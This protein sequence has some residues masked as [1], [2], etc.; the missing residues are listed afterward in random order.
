[1]N[2]Y[3]MLAGPSHLLPKDWSKHKDEYWIGVD[4]GALR[5]IENG[6]TPQIA[7]G[8]FDSTSSNQFKLIEENS[9]KI[10]KLKIEK[11]YTDAEIALHEAVNL[12]SEGK[13]VVFGGTGGRIDHLLNLIY[14]PN[15]EALLPHAE[16]IRLVDQ[17][18]VIRYFKPGD[19]TIQNLPGMSYVAFGAVTPVEGLTLL[20]FKYNL[21][22]YN[23]VESF[24]YTSNEFTSDQGSFSFE[25]GLVIV[26][27][28]RDD[29]N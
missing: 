1:M 20:D 21:D 16:R 9:E 4:K 23:R 8:D 19:H 2:I 29:D 25:K 10:E 22:S 17:D 27:Y 13:I 14:S 18:N 28:S 7:V 5:L 24:V 26:I 11:D 15:H 6:I 12:D 3:I